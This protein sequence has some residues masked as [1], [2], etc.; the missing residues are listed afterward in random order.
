VSA[1]QIHQRPHRVGPK[2]ADGGLQRAHHIF[3]GARSERLGIYRRLPGAAPSLRAPATG[4]SKITHGP[5]RARRNLP[6]AARSASEIYRRLRGA[7]YP[8]RDAN[9]RTDTPESAARRE[10]PP[11][12]AG[13]RGRDTTRPK[14]LPGTVRGRPLADRSDKRA[15]D[16]AQG[17]ASDTGHARRPRP[18]PPTARIRSETQKAAARRE[19][20]QPDA[21]TRD[22]TQMAAAGRRA[23]GRPRHRQGGARRGPPG[24]L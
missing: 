2:S 11:R 22:Q 20:P 16:P 24:S 3:T 7:Q 14:P 4:A 12:D 10:W 6:A 19:N 15:C 18:A 1:S 17:I 21:N 13:T 9:S 8:Q 23:P 5:P